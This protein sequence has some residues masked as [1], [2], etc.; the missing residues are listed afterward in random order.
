MTMP[1]VLLY[2]CSV[3][4][5]FELFFFLML[6]LPPRSTRTD[7]PFPYTTLFRSLSVFVFR[8]GTITLG[9]N[10]ALSLFAWQSSFLL[11][12]LCFREPLR[13]LG[14]AVYPLT[15]LAAIVA[16]AWPSPTNAI[17]I[18]NWKAQLHI[19]L[20]LFSAGLLT[21]RQRAAEGKRVSFRV[22]TVG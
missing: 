5:L 6:R 3:L 13:I 9:F 15:A 10:E 21:T 14:T 8:A 7:T 22:D 12:A 18:D 19:T 1:E 4:S 16:I 20:S 11:W 2:I 17:I